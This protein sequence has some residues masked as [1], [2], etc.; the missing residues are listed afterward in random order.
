MQVRV[1]IHVFLDFNSWIYKVMLCSLVMA[2]W[3]VAT[4]LYLVV[5]A[6]H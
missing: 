5:I 2:T 3:S 4:L 6:L 1:S